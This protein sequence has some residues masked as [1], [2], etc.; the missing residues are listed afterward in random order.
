MSVDAQLIGL[1]LSYKWDTIVPLC[2]FFNI[3][4]VSDYAILLLFPAWFQ[5]YI[6]IV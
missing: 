1:L 5:M 2:D 3:N 4:H 6:S